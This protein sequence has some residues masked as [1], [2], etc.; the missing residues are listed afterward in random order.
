MEKERTTN[1]TKA[2][3]ANHEIHELHESLT[4]VNVGDFVSAEWEMGW[5]RQH[6]ACGGTTPHPDP[7]PV[8]RGEGVEIGRMDEQ[9]LRRGYGQSRLQAGASGR[10]RACGI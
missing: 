7:L 8:R 5:G 6:L 3:S 1:Y 9:A 10:A 4:E 2:N